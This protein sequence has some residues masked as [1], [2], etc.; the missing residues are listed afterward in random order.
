MSGKR[1]LLSWETII[2]LNIHCGQ[3]VILRQVYASSETIQENIA[4]QG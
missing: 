3:M 4:N 1:M 2:G